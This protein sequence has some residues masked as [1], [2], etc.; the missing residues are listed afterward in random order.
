MKI[1]RFILIGAFILGCI[2]FATCSN[3]PSRPLFRNVVSTNSEEFE[4]KISFPNEWTLYERFAMGSLS[5]EL[6]NNFV[7]LHL[8]ALAIS[9]DKKANITLVETRK[10]MSNDALDVHEGQI[11][12]ITNISTSEWDINGTQWRV[13]EVLLVKHVEGEAIPYARSFHTSLYAPPFGTIRLTFT[14]GLGFK[15]EVGVVKEVLA[16]FVYRKTKKAYI[17]NNRPQPAEV[18]VRQLP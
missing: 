14:F 18:D 13:Q 3:Q 1:G 7:R 16:S 12:G 15:G 8:I 6:Q 10:R 2:L 4:Y 9:P 17:H 5:E 11:D